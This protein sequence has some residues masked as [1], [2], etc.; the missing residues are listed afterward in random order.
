MGIRWH[1]SV[2]N[3]GNSAKEN[4]PRGTSQKS[5]NKTVGLILEVSRVVGNEYYS[6]HLMGFR[7]PRDP[8]I[9]GRS[10]AIRLKGRR[11]RLQP[12]EEAVGNRA[13]SWIH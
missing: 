12:K 7:V 10:P 9:H 5:D 2:Y 11:Y 4:A 1:N 13:G 8:Y 6:P 3:E